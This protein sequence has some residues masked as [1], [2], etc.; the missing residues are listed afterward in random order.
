M[1]V[2]PFVRGID[3]RQRVFVDALV[4]LTMRAPVGGRSPVVKE[5]LPKE[6][7]PDDASP[8]WRCIDDTPKIRPIV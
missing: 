3:T 1:L 6:T 2:A 4:G 5:R 7:P 8:E